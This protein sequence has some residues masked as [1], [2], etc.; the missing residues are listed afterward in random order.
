MTRT[1]QILAALF[2]VGSIS[3]MQLPLVFIMIN[4]YDWLPGYVLFIGIELLVCIGILVSA[5]FKRAALLFLG[6]AFLGLVA[7]DFYFS[8]IS[9]FDL[10]IPLNNE[11]YYKDMANPPNTVRLPNRDWL[12]V[13][14]AV[15]A[16]IIVITS[17]IWAN[18]ITKVST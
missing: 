9:P 11:S 10:S 16:C 4:N 18:R 17:K 7:L 15:V 2:M 13:F 12:G 6:F 14:I 1:V 8:F 5:M 3:M